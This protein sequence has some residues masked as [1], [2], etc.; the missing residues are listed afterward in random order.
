MSKKELV[1]RSSTDEFLML[2]KQLY[3]SVFKI[4]MTIVS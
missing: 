3:Q 4:D 1:I 2:K